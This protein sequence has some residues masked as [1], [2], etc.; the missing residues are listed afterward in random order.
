MTYSDETLMAYVDRELDPTTAAAIDAACAQ[1]PELAARVERHRRLRVAVHGAY[2]TTLSEPVPDRLLALARGAGGATS[3]PT[4][5]SA[6]APKVVDLAAARAARDARAE[7]PPRRANW[8]TWGALAASVAIGVWIGSTFLREPLAPGESFSAAGGHLLARGAVAQALDRQLASAQ[9]DT[10]PVQ[11]GV[12]FV[13]HDGLYCRTFAV[14]DPALGGLACKN[15]ADW[16]VQTLAQAATNS[17]Q[18]GGFRMA[19][20]SVPETVLRSVDQLIQGA[21]LDAAA[22]TAA[23]EHGWKR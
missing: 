2:A 1:D 9:A 13:S 21:P 22:E 16:R 5:T 15:G 7:T 3:A 14:R 17:E 23:R 10:A 20:S 12:S 4:G 18:P 8:R 19:G 6:P 11:V